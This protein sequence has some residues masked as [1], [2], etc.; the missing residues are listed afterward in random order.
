MFRFKLRQCYWFGLFDDFCDGKWLSFFD[1][2]WLGLEES[3]CNVFQFV[4]IDWLLAGVG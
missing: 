3:F 4:F 1:G 2:F